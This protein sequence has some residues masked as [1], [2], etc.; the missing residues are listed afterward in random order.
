[1][2]ATIE[3]TSDAWARRTRWSGNEISLG[4]VQPVNLRHPALVAELGDAGRVESEVDGVGGVLADPAGGQYAAEVPVAHQ[5]HVALGESGANAV[6]HLV[7]SGADLL[8]GFAAGARV[9]PDGPVRHG[10]ADLWGGEA[11][12]VAVVPLGEVGGDLVDAEP[13]Q[14]GGAPG[15]GSWAG[16]HQREWPVTAQPGEH[17][18]GAARPRF[19]LLGQRDV[20]APGVPPAL[21]PLG[22]TVSEQVDLAR[23]DLDPNGRQCH[24]TDG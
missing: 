22:L 11:L 8:G 13:G 9:G 21:R 4:D 3:S 6:E 16:Q 12:V 24:V 18:A 15:P 20:G 1:M 10:F 7:R 23:H 19:A 17:L 5:D 14:L 2:S